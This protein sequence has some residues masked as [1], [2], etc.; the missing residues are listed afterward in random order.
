M[1]G[2]QASERLFDDARAIESTGGHGLL[3]AARGR[4]IAGFEAETT[5]T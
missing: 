4:L 2:A 1:Q 5:T 3:R